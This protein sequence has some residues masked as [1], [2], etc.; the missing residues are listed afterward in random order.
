M[1]YSGYANQDIQAVYKIRC[2]KPLEQSPG[3][4]LIPILDVIRLNAPEMAGYR[5]KRTRRRKNRRKEERKFP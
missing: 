4:G 5:E 2:V 1:Q 3:S